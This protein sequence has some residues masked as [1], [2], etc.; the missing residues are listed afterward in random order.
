MTGGNRGIGYALIQ[1]L[2]DRGHRVTFTSRDPHRGV[3]ALNRL[4]A[5]NPSRRLRMEICDASAPDSIREFT[6]RLVEENEPL[7]GLI[8][9]AGVLRPPPQRATVAGDVEATLATNAL[10]PLLITTGLQ[11]LLE[12]AAAGRVLILTSRLHRPGSRGAPVG[13]DFDDPN[14][15]HGYDPD[16]AYKNSKLAAIWVAHE[17][18]QR[19]GPTVTCNAIC[20]GFVPATAAQYTSGW[21]RLLLRHVLPRFA[22]A[23]TVDQA[24]ADVIW[25]LD[26]PELAGVG[27]SYL[28]DR[29]IAESSAE[30]RDPALARR[31]WDLASLLLER[32]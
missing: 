9:N 4:M 2:G 26:N 10:G 18:D 21:Q 20:P 5:E 12:A 19:S 1:A 17:L 31:F 14:L 15:E 7:D 27:G 29:Q 8:H 11:P 3:Q 25:A 13:F 6:R 30:A 28:A 16:R 24:A 23:R 32:A 22:F